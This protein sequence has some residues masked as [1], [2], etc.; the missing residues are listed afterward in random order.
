MTFYLGNK[1][2]TEL[3]N[4]SITEMVERTVNYSC[5]LA[6]NPQ[7]VFNEISLS[8]GQ[9]YFGSLREFW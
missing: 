8:L 7:V 3:V 9:G 5:L 4:L 6:S 1:D 2:N